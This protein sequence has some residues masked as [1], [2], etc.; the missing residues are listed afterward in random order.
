MACGFPETYSPSLRPA[1][2]S[3]MADTYSHGFVAGGEDKHAIQPQR[4]GWCTYYVSDI[5]P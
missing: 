4:H 3:G 2:D 1:R 5:F